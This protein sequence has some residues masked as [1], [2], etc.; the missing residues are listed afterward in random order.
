MPIIEMHMTEGR[1]PEQ[2]SK[3]AAAVT[4]AVCQSL[5]CP[6]HTVRVLIT[7]HR[8]HEFYVGGMTKAQRDAKVLEQAI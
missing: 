5:D 3:V 1:T 7:E 8:E 4:E 2:K 6:A